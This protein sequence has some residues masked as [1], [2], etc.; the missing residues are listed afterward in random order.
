LET[1]VPVDIRIQHGK[2]EV[3]RV[4][5]DVLGLTKLNYNACKPGESKP[6]TIKFSEV[7]GEILVANPGLKAPEAKFKFY[8]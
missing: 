7:V 3:Q 6:V 1:P 4:A 5:R 8:L 2:A